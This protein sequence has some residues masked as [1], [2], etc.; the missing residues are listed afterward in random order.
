METFLTV[1]ALMFVAEIG[2]KTQLVA[3]TFAAKFKLI[4]V[5]LG[6]SCAFI[7]NNLLAVALGSF[8]GE[9]LPLNLVRIAA[10]C[11]FIAFGI[12]TIFGSDEEENASS[13]VIVNQF[14]TVFLFLFVAEFGDKSQIAAMTFSM[15]YHAP[16]AVFLGAVAGEISANLIGIGAGVLLGKTLPIKIIKWI[17]AVVFI[18]IGVTGLI[19]T[20]I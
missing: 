17:S 18:A 4:W 11:L 19:L 1:F 8:I 12:W 5:I 7:L 10:Y 9:V 14:V 2:D 15:K 6:L 20:I 16:I 3:L 13:K